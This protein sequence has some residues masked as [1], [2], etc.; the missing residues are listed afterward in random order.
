M[1]PPPESVSTCASSPAPNRKGVF[2]LAMTVLFTAFTTVILM[3]VTLWYLDVDV[4]DT[5][6]SAI[7]VGYSI[8]YT[9]HMPRAVE[10]AAEY[11]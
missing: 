4:P 9:V 11:F 3:A 10:E 7:G 5:L 6:D 1:E 2:S 8:L